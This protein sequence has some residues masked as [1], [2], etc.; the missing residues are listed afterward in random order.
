MAEVYEG[1]CVLEVDGIEVDVTKLNVKIKT[2]RKLVK[3]MNSTGRA[4]GYAQGIEEITLSI[5]A[6]EP[7]DGTV[8]DWKN[9]KDAK[10]TKY[11]LNNAEKRTSYLGCFTIDVGAS[12]SVD[13]ETQ[14]DVEMGALREVVE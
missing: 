9:I 3:T 1:S 11:P 5:T 10:L 14:V 4:K 7:K 13:D 2:G 6:V 12:H 8:I